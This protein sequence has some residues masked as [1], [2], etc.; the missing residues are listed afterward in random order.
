MTTLYH[1]TT[2]NFDES[3]ENLDHCAQIGAQLDSKYNSR[4]RSETEFYWVPGQPQP[5]GGLYTIRRVWTDAQALSE[6]AA[7]INGLRG[8][9]P[10]V[11]AC[12]G[13][14][15]IRNDNDYNPPV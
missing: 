12:V 3:P 8:S 1:V 9:D 2:W 7:E 4:G 10:I 5:G 11:A 15:E 13:V 14:P 6:W